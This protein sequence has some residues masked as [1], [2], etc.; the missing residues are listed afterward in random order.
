[1]NRIITRGLGN[2]SMVVTRGYGYSGFVKVFRE[3]MRL[4]SRISRYLNIN[5]KLKGG[6]C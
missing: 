1:M 3:M 5:S 2:S 4:T 6:D